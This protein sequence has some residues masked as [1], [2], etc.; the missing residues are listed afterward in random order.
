MVKKMIP[1]P[2]I[3]CDRLRHI[4]MLCGWA[5]QLSITVAPVDVNPD[6]VSKKALATSGSEPLKRKGNMPAS[7]KAIHDSVTTR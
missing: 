7:E 1:I 4:R 3:H 2:P 6:I 5:S